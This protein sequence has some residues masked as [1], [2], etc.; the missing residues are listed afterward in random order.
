MATVSLLQQCHRVRDQVAR[1]APFEVWRFHARYGITCFVP[2]FA[3]NAKEQDWFHGTQGLSCGPPGSEWSDLNNHTEHAWG[4]VTR[5]QSIM[6]RALIFGL[7]KSSTQRGTT[8]N[9]QV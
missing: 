4:L 1:P 9:A 5:L 7:F 8:E 2:T 3:E 6:L